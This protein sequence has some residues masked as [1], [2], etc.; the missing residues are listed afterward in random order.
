MANSTGIVDCEPRS[1]AKFESL[2]E[3]LHE[4]IKSKDLLRVRVFLQ[5]S[6]VNGIQK[7]LVNATVYSSW[8]GASLSLAVRHWHITDCGCGW[9]T[10]TKSERCTTSVER[11]PNT[12][13]IVRLLLVNGAD[14]L[15]KDYY[16]LNA[17]ENA[18]STEKLFSDPAPETL[19]VFKEFGY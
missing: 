12:N 1:L 5:S 16:D 15:I 9:A 11:N 6:R 2:V 8:F 18:V 19:A 10:E 14:P 13:E 7:E 17:L 4:L 3:Q